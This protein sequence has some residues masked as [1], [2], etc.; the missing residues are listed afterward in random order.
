MVCS[1]GTSAADRNLYSKRHGMLLPEGYTALAEEKS[2]RKIYRME[3]IKEGLGLKF[4]VSWM[5]IFSTMKALL[6]CGD[7]VNIL[8]WHVGD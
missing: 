6:E 7:T 3:I 5:S 1:L 2:T 8:P 4:K